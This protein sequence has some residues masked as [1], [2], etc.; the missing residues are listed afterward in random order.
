MLNEAAYILKAS[1]GI[2]KHQFIEDETLKRALVRSIEIIGEAT[3]RVPDDFREKFPQ[4]EWRA[5]AGMRDKF[6][7]DYFGVDYDLV[8]D[9]VKNKI[10]PLKNHLENI[11]RQETQSK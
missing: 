4:I 7:H 1:N 9:V 5:M 2:E 8:W 3:K 11:I 6:I 10:P